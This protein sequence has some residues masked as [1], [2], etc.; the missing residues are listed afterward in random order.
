[1]GRALD[2]LKALG[3][4]GRARMNEVYPRQFKCLVWAAHRER[5]RED[6]WYF[7]TRILKNDIL[8]ESLHK[9]W[10]KSLERWPK[11][12]KLRLAARG[13]LKSTLH[14]IGYSV[15]EI[16]RN[17]NIRILLNSHRQEDAAAYGA[18]IRKTIDSEDYRW[19]YPE[20]SKAMQGN[21]EVCWRDDAFEVARSMVFKE[22]TVETASVG[23]IPVGRHYNLIVYVDIVTDKNCTSPAMRKKTTDFVKACRPLLDPGGRELFEGTRYNYSDEYGR[24]M[25]EEADSFDFEVQ[26]AWIGKWEERRAIYPKRFTFAPEHVGDPEHSG[27]GRWSLPK[28]K[29]ELGTYVFS[30]QYGNEPMDD[31]AALFKRD[32]LEPIAA[33]PEKRN[34]VRLRVTD[35]SGEGDTKSETAI[36]DVAVD[37]LANIYIENIIVG[38][39]SPSEIVRELHRA[40]SLPESVRPQMV[41]GERAMLEKVVKHYSDI[42]TAKT[43]VL[44]PW[45][46]LPGNQ[47]QKSKPD[48]VRG[49]EPWVTGGK[50][51]ILETCRNKHVLIDQLTRFPH[52]GDMDVADACAQIP[53]IMWPADSSKRAESEEEKRERETREWMERQFGDLFNDDEESDFVVGGH[54][55][56]G[57]ELRD[58]LVSA[59]V[60][61]L[62][63]VA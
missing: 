38:Q 19:V 23:T 41:G 52:A 61:S 49:L 24:I 39:F 3:P 17:Q 37:D 1:M 28:L 11:L 26:A 45:R 20:V 9:P 25:R 59:T 4:L 47:A 22:R 36:V 57:L 15:W 8:E 12:K 34:Y 16:T 43:G 14:G 62:R 13:H 58:A 35:L 50:F 44:I 27:E 21:K 33:L 55:V 18:A 40:Q 7:L 29:E 51:Y 54:T 48:R 30:C 5:G 31:E 56:G 32:A 2:K 42:E 6:Y 10:A 63:R 53:H 60:N 46:W